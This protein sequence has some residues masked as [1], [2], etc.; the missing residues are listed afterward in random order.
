MTFP[1]SRER[2]TP[3]PTGLKTSLTTSERVDKIANFCSWRAFPVGNE[4]ISLALRQLGLKRS[5]YLVTQR[6][7]LLYQISAHIA[8]KPFSNVTRGTNPNAL[9]LLIS[10]EDSCTSPGRLG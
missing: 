8:V 5:N 4:L 3:A 10:A 6:L 7:E 2:A 9:I 1:M